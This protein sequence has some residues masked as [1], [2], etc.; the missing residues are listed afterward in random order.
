MTFETKN[1]LTAQDVVAYALDGLVTLLSHE[2]ACAVDARGIAAIIDLIRDKL[3]EVHP[4]PDGVSR[5]AAPDRSAFQQFADVGLFKEEFIRVAA[6]E[7]EQVIDEVRMSLDAFC[8]LTGEH[9]ARPIAGREAW[10]LANVIHNRLDDY[11]IGA[12]LSEAMAD[13]HRATVEAAA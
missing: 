8:G 11:V 9:D 2:T 12:D 5:R 13:A 10:A 4:A 7:N 6:W 1:N 3:A